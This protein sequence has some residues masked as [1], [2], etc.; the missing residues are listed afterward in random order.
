[1]HNAKRWAE[2]VVLPEMD[3]GVGRDRGGPCA[4]SGDDETR[5]A[6]RQMM[7]PKITRVL[8]HDPDGKISG[9][10]VEAM[11]IVFG[12]QFLRP[13]DP[14]NSRYVFAV[15]HAIWLTEDAQ[16]CWLPRGDQES[17]GRASAALAGFAL[18][19]DRF[20]DTLRWLTCARKEPGLEHDKEVGHNFSFVLAHVED[21]YETTLQQSVLQA[22]REVSAW[23]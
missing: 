16:E 8:P 23:K 6:C 17:A 12:A 4:A 10:H 19:L 13:A 22:W 2:S 9:L 20:G 1:M 11:A 3:C 15:E 5:A 7:V 14:S 18:E 21:E